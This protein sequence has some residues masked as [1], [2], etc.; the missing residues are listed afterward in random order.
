[1]PSFDV[2]SQVNLQEVDNALNQ[3]VKEIQTRYDFRG[4]KSEIRRGGDR[5]SFAIIADDEFKRK[6][7]LD[8]V[9]SKLARRGVSLKAMQP[10]KIEPAS[11]GTLRQE[12]T[13][14]LGI[15]IE[16]AREIVKAIKET[17]LKVQA[18][19]QDD[20]VRVS[21]KSKDDLQ[22]AIQALKAKDFGLDLQFINYRD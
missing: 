4:S 16:K 2:V 3:A 21:G 19:I 5:A 13:F 22:A 6:A 18:Q 12:V 11:G 10:G 8:V 14:Q 15:P 17:K 7:V 20:Q 1:M 9:Q